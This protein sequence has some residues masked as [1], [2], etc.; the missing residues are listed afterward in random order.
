MKTELVFYKPMPFLSPNQQPQSTEG[1]ANTNTIEKI[2]HW[3][4]PSMIHQLTPEGQNAAILLL[5]L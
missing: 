1:N 4:Y 3:S 2:T 5:A